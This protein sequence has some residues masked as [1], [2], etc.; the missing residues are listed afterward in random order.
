MVA[1]E[2]VRVVRRWIGEEADIGSGLRERIADGRWSASGIEMRGVRVAGVGR[3]GSG[4]DVIWKAAGCSRDPRHLPA[5]EDPSCQPFG[6]VVMP[7]TDGKYPGVVDHHPLS[8][9]EI[10]VTAL[11]GEVERVAREFL[12]A[13]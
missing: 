4:K 1:P 11:G 13:G 3:I 12:V 9:V 7:A 8:Y 10:G 2:V 5:F 6:Q